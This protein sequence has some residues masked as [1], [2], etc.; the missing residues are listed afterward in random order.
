[1]RDSPR[2]PSADASSAVHATRAIV[3]VV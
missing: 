1:M 3:S 2:P